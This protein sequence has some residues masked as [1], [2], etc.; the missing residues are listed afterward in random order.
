[1]F[2]F[3]GMW[4]K[5]RKFRIASRDRSKTTADSYI[6]SMFDEG[7]GEETQYMGQ[8]DQI[9][10]LTYNSQQSVL[11]KGKWWNNKI[12]LQGQSTTLIPDECGFLRLYA[13]EFMLD[14]LPQ[15]EPFV[16]P[17][18]VDQIFLVKG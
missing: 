16:F 2:Y 4:S 12:I 8:I 7:N 13:K 3:A 11:F 1:M 18:D 15:H 17:K 10:R 5:G 9:V 14:H 6:S